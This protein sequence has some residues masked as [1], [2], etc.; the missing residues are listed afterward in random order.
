MRTNTALATLAVL[1]ASLFYTPAL[2]QAEEGARL[3]LVIVDEA[4]HAVPNATVTI[5]TLDGKPG[6]TVTTDVKGVA[7]LTDLPTGL[8]EIYARIPGQ[9][10]YA[11]PA[12]LHRGE[13]KQRIT[14]RLVKPATSADTVISGS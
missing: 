11:E 4:D 5:F 1:A 7:V 6:R 9:A 14:L 12:T 3:R 2:A 8:S 13:N 10:S